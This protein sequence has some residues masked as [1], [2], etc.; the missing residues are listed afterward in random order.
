MET[1]LIE[2]SIEINAS[3]EKVWNVL[4]L[5]QYNLQW[6]H[7]FSEG[8]HAETDWKVGSKTV[9]T[10]HSNDGMIGRVI[11]NKPGESLV[12]E[13]EGVIMKGVEDYDSDVAQKVKGGR[14]SYILTHS[15]GTTSLYISCDM[16]PEYFDMMSGQWDIA[17]EKIKELSENQ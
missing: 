6:Y 17:L 3:K 2:K 13:Y 12:I 14:E 7:A 8:T 9:F 1:Q 10:D 5:D 16:D 4:V 11:E 15:N